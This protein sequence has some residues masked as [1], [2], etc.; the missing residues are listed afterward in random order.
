[1]VVVFRSGA[2]KARGVAE[3]REAGGGAVFESLKFLGVDVEADVFGSG[4]PE[5]A[6]GT[7]AASDVEDE[8]CALLGGGLGAYVGGRAIGGLGG[9]RSSRTTFRGGG[10]GFGGGGGGFGGG[11]GGFGGGGASGRW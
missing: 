10:G 7:G 6:D 8:F 5:R 1:M 11:G 3:E 4:V 9:G 2:K